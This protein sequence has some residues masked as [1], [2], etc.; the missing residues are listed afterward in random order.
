LAAYV[1]SGAA[2]NLLSIGVHQ[3]WGNGAVGAGASGAVFGLAGVLIVLLKSPRLPIPRKELNGLRRYV[4]YFAAINFV[5]GFGGNHFFSTV[6][7]DNWAHLG[8]FVGGILFALPLVP[9]LGSP[10][11]LFLFRRRLAMSAL[12]TG[13]F[14]FAYFLS[15][16]FPAA[17]FVG[18]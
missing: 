9:M 3:A 17:N 10:K 6:Q 13:L 2:G 5:V 7:V 18:R 1:L 4:I 12:T 11:R 15:V 16:V 8:G 14:F